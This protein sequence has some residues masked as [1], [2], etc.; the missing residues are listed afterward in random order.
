MLYQ[1]SDVTVTLGGNTIFSNVSMEIKEKSKIALVGPN[2][3]GKTTLLNVLMG[4]ILPDLDDKR[5]GAGVKSSRKFTRGMLKQIQCLNSVQTV[6][7]YLLEGATELEPF[8]RERFE[9]EVEFDRLFTG[10]GFAKE[11]KKKK[12]SEFS[13]GEITKISFIELLLM[14][15]DLLLL[16]EPTNHL[17]LETV[18]WL[19]QYM[20][21]Y[22]K[23]V[24]FVSHDRFFLDRVA[25]EVYELENG[26]LTHYSGN[27]TQFRKQKHKNYE[28]QKKQYD[29]QQEEM[30]R[31]EDLIVRFKNKPTKAAFARSKKTQLSRMK[32]I[33]KPVPSVGHVFVKPIEPEF[34]GP[35]FV[36]EAEKLQIGYQ[37]NHPLA[38][39]SLRLRRGQKIAVIGA[40][41]VGKSTFLKTVTGDLAPLKGKSQFGNNILMG[42]FEQ[43]SANR[44]ED[45]T[46]Y[47]YFRKAFPTLEEKELRQY[48]ANFLFQKQEVYKKIS[49]LSG[50][51]RARFYLAQMLYQKPNFMVLDEPT[52]H[53]D[54]RAKETLESAF[55][56]YRGSML[57]V[58]HD[59]YFVSRVADAILLFENNK[60]YYYPFGYEHYL[61]HAKYAD[62]E[63]ITALISAED[64]AMVEGLRAVPKPERHRLKEQNTELAYVDWRRAL[65]AEPIEFAWEQLMEAL[66]DGND[67]R[68]QA[69]EDCVTQAC[70]DYYDTFLE[71]E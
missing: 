46:L 5:Q 41:G 63:D 37:K 55:S 1:L 28:L 15:P 45:T 47:D 25:D 2:G 18:E 69:Q 57:F 32:Q 59:R 33:E 56:V 26:R 38:E 36:Y 17:D 71:T 11:D 20:R 39:V 68:I 3:A 12:L 13:G 67:D 40:N 58:S 8:S 31:L 30:K 4:E 54:I 10:F 50:G 65:A 48:L 70:L 23:A 60:V 51:E 49:D 7:D 62:S 52:N 22:T 9:Y 61:E 24:V 35:K 42:I 27:Y 43:D 29:A 34:P 19:E 16:D 6:E 64:Q 66:M 53:M 14:Q 21:G 44:L